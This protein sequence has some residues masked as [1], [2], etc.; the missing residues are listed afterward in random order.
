VFEGAGERATASRETLHENEGENQ[1]TQIIRRLEFTAYILASVFFITLP[2]VGAQTYPGAG[3]VLNV[4]PEHNEIV[5]SMQEIPGFMDAMVMPLPVRNARNLR[6]IRRGMM[7][8]FSLVV[9][10]TSSYAENV[11]VHHFESLENDPQAACRLAIIDKALAGTTPSS[12][13]LALGQHVPDFSLTD[14]NGRPV[15]LSQFS[16]KVVAMTFVYTRCPLPNFCFRLSN[17]FGQIQQRFSRQMG[18][19]LILLTITLD[20]TTDQAEALAKYASIWKADGAS[21]HFLTGPPE[22]IKE[23]TG[24]FGVVSAIDEGTI[25]HS[26]HTVIIDRRGNLATNLEGNE[27][28]GKQLGDLVEAEMDR[29]LGQPGTERAGLSARNQPSQAP[30]GIER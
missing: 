14:Q 10:E 3:L 26:L 29:T 2:A 23:I 8:D 20:P 4:N 22:T 1:M 30:N 27:F 16:G 11:R 21:W 7:V 19:D 18:R 12:P 24:R 6:G 5:V 9:T 15:S 28:T 13:A 25:T 17:N